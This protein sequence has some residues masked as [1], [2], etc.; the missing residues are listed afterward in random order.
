MRV[1]CVDTCRDYRY[2]VL[3]TV[4]SS[5]E[6]TIIFYFKGVVVV[7]DAE[8]VVSAILFFNAILYCYKDK[9]STR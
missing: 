7:G 1:L 8:N 4:G 6:I 5:K 9:L 2:R 3:M